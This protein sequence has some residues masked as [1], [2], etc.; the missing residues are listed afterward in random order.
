MTGGTGLR[1]LPPCHRCWGIPLH[2]ALFSAGQ[3]NVHKHS[4]VN[5]A[6]QPMPTPAQL[7]NRQLYKF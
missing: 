1:I 6:C 3:Y 4:A 2:A 7:S 5:P